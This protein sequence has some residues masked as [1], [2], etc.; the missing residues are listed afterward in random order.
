MI[1]KNLISE[2]IHPLKQ[3]DSIEL[4]MHWMDENKCEHLPVISENN[5]YL[6]IVSEELLLNASSE[7]MLSDFKTQFLKPAVREEEHIFDVIKLM[8]E[9][10]LSII[11]VIDKSETYLGSISQKNVIR[12]LSKFVSATDP[13][14]II[15]LEMNKRDYFLTQIVNIIEGNECKVLGVYTSPADDSTKLDVTIKVNTEDLSRIIQTFERFNYNVLATFHQGAYEQ[16]MKNKF[17]EFMHYLS[18]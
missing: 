1:A 13:G 11:P 17:D 6:G 2:K 15:V 16:D 8:T 9:L 12:E 4:A 3:M 7:E 14:G 18:I 10:N 5:Q